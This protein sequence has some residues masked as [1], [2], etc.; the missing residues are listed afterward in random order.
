MIET[1]EGDVPIERI[2]PGMLVRTHSGALRSV[3]RLSVRS[4]R[5]AL[6][7]ATIGDDKR[8]EATPEH[9]VLTGRGWQAA[10]RLRV[11]DLVV[12]LVSAERRFTPALVTALD[13]VE[14]DGPV[15]NF[16]VAVDK[17][18]VVGGIVVHNCLC[19][20]HAVIDR[21][22]FDRSADEGRVP[23]D[24]QDHESPDATAWLKQ[25]PG[26]ARAILGPTRHAALERGVQVLEPTG[27]IK[28]VSALV[29]RSSRK[30]GAR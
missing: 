5:G 24:M 12:T 18:Y 10:E 1:S 20:V 4:W 30:A 2:V 19:T 6:V 26:K 27:Q 8:L 22:H 14:Y 16:A 11:G 3:L 13:R 17:T 21:S 9:E 25:N 7:V 23:A 15:H 28:R 29:Q